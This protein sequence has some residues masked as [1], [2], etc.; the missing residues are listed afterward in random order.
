VI[1]IQDTRVFKYDDGRKTVTV[2]RDFDDA[3]K[4]YIVPTPRFA[5][6]S[7]SGKAVPAF[8]LTEYATNLG[9]RGTAAMT[10]ELVIDP[11]ARKAAEEQLPPG[12]IFGQLDWVQAQAFLRFNMG[13]REVVLNTVPSLYGGNEATFVVELK[14]AE[15]VNTFRDA[16]QPG[17][18]IAP[19]QFNV[20]YQVLA[21][22][23]LPAVNVAVNYDSVIAVDYQKK[24]DISRNVWGSETSRRAS[25]Q[26]NLRRSDAGKVTISWS[27]PD[28]SEELQQRVNDWAWVTLEG[29]VSMAMDD[30]MR[31]VGE[32]NLDQFSLTSTASFS[33]NYSENQVIQWAIT[34]G[35]F[36]P[37]FTEEVWRVVYRK[38]ENRRLVVNFTILDNLTAAGIQSVLMKINYPSA[39][40]GNTF[41]FKPGGPASWTA[42]FDGAKVDAEF[43]P[44]YTYEYT[45]TFNDGTPPF[46]EPP[47]P[48]AATQVLLPVAS[49]GIQSASFIGSNI[50][51]TTSNGVDFVLIDFFFHTP[52]DVPNTVEQ[53]RMTDNTTV[54]EIP[55]RT[56]LPSANEYSYQ[57]TYVM[58]NKSRYVVSPQPVFAPQN[59]A[60]NTIFSPFV[61]RQA[62]V[63]VSN[64]TDVTPK[65]MMVDLVGQYQDPQNT[66]SGLENGWNFELNPEKLLTSGQR[67][68]FSA[69]AN[70]NGAFILYS[71]T[72]FYDDGS[73]FVVEKIAISG[74]APSLIINAKLQPFT[75]EIDPR[76]IAWDQ[77]VESV[78]VQMFLS[79][80]EQQ[81][82]KL[83]T[84][85]GAGDETAIS[86]FTFLPPA[87]DGTGAL[88]PVAKQYYMFNHA[89]DKPVR[90]FWAA[91]YFHKAGEKTVVA[92][93]DRVNILT[94]PPDG[95]SLERVVNSV[96]VPAAPLRRHT[97]A[98]RRI[99]QTR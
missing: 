58:K 84:L 56:H 19:T 43:D 70:P 99:W 14:S 37:N 31:R 65:V 34:P 16:F 79:T 24:V 66:A 5:T 1:N 76:L 54:I 9:A 82:L 52:G 77:G 60:L 57:L 41:T 68:S 29:L 38:V 27:I 35:E 18:G 28:P 13:G 78:D 51:F 4:W 8:S 3:N 89:V 59:R 61:G 80:A 33:R 92:T 12:S 88:L 49:L 98:T 20:Q 85:G 87:K 94:L 95:N 10:V 93:Q 15:E 23:K 39:A 36:L 42:D 32:R 44:N 83:A 30:A 47:I 26:E 69:V 96:V 46:S 81:G 62:A 50:D 2:Y 90:Y 73:S 91:R 25:I 86:V 11:A 45:V 48:S 53:K 71:G 74:P 7:S 63:F 72:V 6:I 75:V 17:S 67:W 55:S 97:P 21:L 64:P 22:A 40:T